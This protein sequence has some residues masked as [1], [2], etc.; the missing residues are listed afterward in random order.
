[1]KIL[2]LVFTYNTSLEDWVKNGSIDRELDIYKILLTYFDRIYF[3][4]YGKDDA[5]FQDKLPS[6][7]IILPKK[8]NLNNLFYSLIIPLTY[9]KQ[10]KKTSFVKTNQMI[11]SWTAILIKILFNKKLILRT[12]YTESLF[13]IGKNIV[14]KKI[15]GLLE[16]TSYKF[17]NISIVTTMEQK[18][19]LQKKYAITSMNIIPNGINTKIFSYAKNTTSIDDTLRLF[20]VG[21]LHPE[22]NIINLVKALKGLKNIK[23]I[24]VG[25]GLLKQNILKLRKKYNLTIKIID[26]I[27]NSQLPKFYNNADIYIQPSIYEGNPKTILEAMSC[28]L[29]VIATDVKGINNVITHKEN[30]YLCDTSSKSIRNAIIKLREDSTLQ[31]KIRQNARKYIVQNYNLKKIIEKEINLYKLN[32]K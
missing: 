4:T 27:P 10:L 13:F 26:K 18:K 6:S 7:I 2:T 29:P 3:I 17:S 31:E 30:G 5:K 28:G 20:F 19:Y 22:K 11:G 14:I 1:M 21:R 32:E 9:K 8:Y 25:T 12:G 16:Y 24:I 23:L 15:I